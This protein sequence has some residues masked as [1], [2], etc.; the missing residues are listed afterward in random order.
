MVVLAKHLAAATRGVV[1]FTD[2]PGANQVAFAPLGPD[3]RHRTSWQLQIGHLLPVPASDMPLE[4]VLQFRDAYEDERQELAHAVL[5]LM[6]S[7][8]EPGDEADPVAVQQHIEKA[9]QRLERA[10]HDR[11]ILWMK[12]R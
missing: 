7:M 4:K 9:V 1:P 5:K 6:L 8:S 11:G 12:R 10:G 2:S 3:L